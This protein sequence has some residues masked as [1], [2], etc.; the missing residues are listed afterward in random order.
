VELINY[1]ETTLK[2]SHLQ[3]KELFLLMGYGSHTP[4]E[5]ILKI[6]DEQFSY[7]QTICR[8]YCGYKICYGKPINK[9]QLEIEGVIINPGKIITSAMKEAEQIAVFTA[10]LGGEFDN[11]LHT[12]HMGDNILYDFIANSIGSV[13]AEGIVNELMDQLLFDVAKNGL[14][15]SNTYS[16]GYCDWALTEQRKLFSILPSGKTRIKLTDSCLML[17]VKSVSGIVA[18]GKD[19]KKRA[20]KCE[21][22]TMN[23]CVRNSKK[24]IISSK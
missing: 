7:L 21:I 23:N 15:I 22:C 17:P 9:K 19:V 1:F 16:P 3:K 20:Y 11:W 24:T 18:I 14:Q 8:P 12:L 4:S 2:S 6:I 5:D 10:T 13:L